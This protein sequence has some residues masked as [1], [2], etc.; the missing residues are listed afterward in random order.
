MDNNCK[1]TDIHAE[2][3]PINRRFKG[4]LL[5]NFKVEFPSSSNDSF[6]FFVQIL[7]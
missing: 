1:I 7:F 5:I 3:D 6:Q 4:L 2:N